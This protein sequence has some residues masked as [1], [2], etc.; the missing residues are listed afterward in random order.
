MA[1]Q[2]PLSSSVSTDPSTGIPLGTWERPSDAILVIGGLAL[3]FVASLI[4]L[5]GMYRLLSAKLKDSKEELE[6][7]RECHDEELNQVCEVLRRL[8]PAYIAKDSMLYGLCVKYSPSNLADVPDG[9]FGL[10][11]MS[12]AAQTGELGGCPDEFELQAVSPSLYLRNLPPHGHESEANRQTSSRASRGPRGAT[13]PSL[14]VCMSCSNCA[15]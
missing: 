8:H 1:P 11:M 10:Y 12:G 9:S 14:G 4:I 15:V 6:Y 7:A 13:P 5:L 3:A 2:P